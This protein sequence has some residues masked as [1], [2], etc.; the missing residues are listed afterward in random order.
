MTGV[1]NSS[2]IS[3]FLTPCKFKGGV[4]DI[5]EYHF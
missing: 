2:Q 4:G 1:E 5:S 3:H